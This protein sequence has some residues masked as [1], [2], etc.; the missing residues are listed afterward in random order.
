M[1]IEEMK[2]L[3]VRAVDRDS[4]VDITTIEIDNSLSPEERTK[5]YLRQVKNPYFF[6][7]GDVV[8]H[9]IFSDDSVTLQDRLEQY[10]N[11]FR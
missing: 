10:V 11:S 5:E 3:D 1:T 6:R 4:L 9:T 2:N 8:V 7:V